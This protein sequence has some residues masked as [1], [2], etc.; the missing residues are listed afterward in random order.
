[1]SDKL[2]FLATPWKI[3][4]EKFNP[5]INA[6]NET[7]FALSNGFIGMRGTFEEGYAGD[8][9]QTID[10]TYLNGFY[11]TDI[12]RYPEG[13]YGYAKTNQTML[14]VTNSRYIKLY[15]DDE[16]FHM[17]CPGVQ[18]YRRELDLKKGFTKREVTWQTKTGKRVKVDITRVVP[19]KH[20]HLAAIEFK[21]TPLNF[22][23]KITLISA[24]DGEVTNVQ[25]DDDPRKALGAAAQGQV[26]KLKRKTHEGTFA[27]IS[28][29]T[30]NS[31]FALACAMENELQGS[32]G[33]HT[34]DE[35]DQKVRLNYL[36]EAKEGEPVILTKYISYFTSQRHPKKDLVNLAKQI[37]TVAKK[38]G[39]AKLLDEQEAYLEKFWHYADVEV[40][41]D[42]ALQQG[43]R[44]NRFHLLQSVGKDGK[45][46]I[47]S[48][49]VT[50]E[51]Y[52]GHYFWDT[53][54][55]VFP[56]FLYSNP[57]ICRKLLEYRYSILPQAR[58][59]A[60]D[61]NHPKGALYVWRT[62][63]GD[64]CSP[65]F[66][67][68]TAQYHINSDIIYA[69]K[70]YT[71]TTNDME[72]MKE[73]GAEMLFETAR[74]FEDVGHYSPK[75]G[76]K[77]CIDCVTGPDEYTACVNNNFYTNAMAQMNLQ[78]A[79]DIAHQLQKE[80]PAAYKKVADKIG[81]EA[82]EIE[83]WKK[84]ADNMYLPYDKE[85]GIHEQDDG[86][87]QKK[88]WPIDTIPADKRPLL[89]HY[90]YLVIYRHQINKQA[91]TL[92]AM[93]FLGNKFSKEDK[94]RDYDYYEK[95][96]THDSSLSMC[97]FS[98]LAAELGY[99]DKAYNYFAQ[100][101]RLDLENGQRN[102]SD[103]IHAAN[104]AGTWMGIVNGFGGMRMYDGA[105]SFNP[106]LPK[107]WKS[108]SFRVFFQ[109][110]LLLATVKPGQVE[111][112]LLEGD[113][114]TFKHRDEVVKL[115]SGESKTLKIG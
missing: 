67:A 19:L 81:L 72:F 77:F 109:S 70:T 43:I 63:N 17:F 107:Q 115:S 97:S 101:A 39:F 69:L 64:E 76:G 79:Y 41:G 38:E 29:E 14:N 114:L 66:P 28:Q 46:N 52:G 75:K 92:L 22:S 4:E 59:R 51:G 96:T 112:K 84:A 85:L 2:N 54:A 33:A 90:H 93:F 23:G 11:E 61:L 49:G 82:G 55:Y 6:E 32:N 8:P 27:A 25:A 86:F 7:I 12:I 24:L 57:D 18:E 10:G 78:Y 110:N 60:R 106:S 16:L 104:M 88:L 5:E 37:V 9:E 30:T 73:C 94:K 105:L 95:I 100:T 31:G 53:E 26:L 21:V 98:I 15:I 99:Y 71:E 48:K 20:Q 40:E 80:D 13:A 56:S 91:D 89:M 83:A 47:A 34:V 36:V 3:I 50:G 65:F 113:G 111:Y 103:G 62:I 74:V 45:T 35:P 108:Y 1:M 87:L 102:T 58:N 44:F 68:G 42:D